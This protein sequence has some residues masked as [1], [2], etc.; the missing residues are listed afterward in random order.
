MDPWGPALVAPINP[1]GERQGA[2]DALAR[3][4]DQAKSIGS[5]ANIKPNAACF[6]ATPNR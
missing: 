6:S 5:I 4:L 3:R 2:G 1:I